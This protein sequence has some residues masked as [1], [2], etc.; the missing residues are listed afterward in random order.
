MIESMKQKIRSAVAKVMVNNSNWPPDI[1][2]HLLG[3][4]MSDQIGLVSGEVIKVLTPSP[5]KV[6]WQIESYGSR[7]YSGL[8]NYATEE[9]ALEAWD[10]DVARYPNNRMEIRRIETIGRN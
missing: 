3:R 2:P 1:A 5:D 9:K 8:Q 7:G 10:K 6:Y 4:D